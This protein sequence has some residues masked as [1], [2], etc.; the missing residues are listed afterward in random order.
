AHGMLKL[1]YGLSEGEA[2]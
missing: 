2:A 1:Y